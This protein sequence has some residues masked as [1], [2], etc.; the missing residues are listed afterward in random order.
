[1][2]TDGHGFSGLWQPKT[3]HPKGGLRTEKNIRVY[4]CPS[5]VSFFQLPDLG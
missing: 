3:I 5:V 2:D 1:M 4:L